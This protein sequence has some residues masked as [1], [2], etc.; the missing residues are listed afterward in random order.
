MVLL[1]LCV[2]WCSDG[3]RDASLMLPL[4]ARSGAESCCIAQLPG[5]ELGLGGVNLRS[6]NCASW[7]SRWWAMGWTGGR[8]TTVALFCIQWRMERTMKMT[9]TMAPTTA[10]TATMMVVVLAEF[11]LLGSGMNKPEVGVGEAEE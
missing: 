1:L 8:G 4:P 3:M 2:R 6:S 11:F 9:R 5:L 10:R 7:C